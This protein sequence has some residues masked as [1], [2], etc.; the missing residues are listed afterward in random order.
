MSNFGQGLPPITSGRKRTWSWTIHPNHLAQQPAKQ[1]KAAVRR[2]HHSEV[3]ATMINGEAF[4]EPS[5]HLQSI[6]NLSKISREGSHSGP[7]R[8]R[9][10]RVFNVILA[11]HCV[12][13]WAVSVLAL[14]VSVLA[15]AVSELAWAVSLSEQSLAATW[16]T[17]RPNHSEFC[18][19]CFVCLSESR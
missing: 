18:V 5:L 4:G 9:T 19:K 13:P 15:W 6:F 11:T 17:H 1:I 16:Q 12:A 7:L 2:I 10:W 3:W 14:V 8:F